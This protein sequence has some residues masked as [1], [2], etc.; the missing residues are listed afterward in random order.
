MRDW[1]VGIEQV[2]FDQQVGQNGGDTLGGGKDHRERIFLPPK[3]PVRIGHARPE[4]HDHLAA[5]VDAVRGPDLAALFHVPAEGV[6]DRGEARV[7][8]SMN[9]H[10][11]N[12]PHSYQRRRSE[13]PSYGVFRE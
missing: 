3:A 6:A 8:E 9:F 7:G 12:E 10:D 4:V 5:V 11:L 1:Q 13:A 2:A